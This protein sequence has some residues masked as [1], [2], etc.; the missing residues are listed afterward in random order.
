MT[1]RLPL[2]ASHYRDRHGRLRTRFRR[3]GCKSYE[4]KA[5]ALSPEWWVEYHACLS[6]ELVPPVTPGADRT[7]PGTIGDMIVR[8]YRSADWQRP[9]ESTRHSFR[10]VIERFRETMDDVPVKSFTYEHASAV[11]ARMKDKPSAANKMRKLLARVWDEGMRLGLVSVNPWRLTRAYR[12]AG[13]HH[14]WTEAEIAAFKATYK[15]GTRER[16][17]L[18][19]MLNTVQRRSDAIRLGPQHVAGGRLRFTQKKTGKRLDMPIVAEL[20]EALEG[21]EAAHL[22]FLVTAHGR[23]FTDAGFGNWFGDAC[24]AAGVPGRAHGLRKAAAV[25]LAEAGATQQ[26]IKAW[27]GHSSDQEVRRYT[28]QANVARLADAAERKMARRGKLVA[29]RN[30]GRGEPSPKG[31]GGKDK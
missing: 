10:L 20:R 2:Y 28:E 5:K 15:V 13:G 17:A 11:L 24:R 25:R 22:T 1:K 6:G 12:E 19:L 26:E 9:S 7:I 4:F 3:K 23:P 29:N 31:L 14:T 8:F 21:F 18:A 30:P 16:L 27:T